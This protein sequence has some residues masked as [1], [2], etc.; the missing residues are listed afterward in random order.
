M[1]KLE[2]PLFRGWKAAYNIAFLIS[3]SVAF[4]IRFLKSNY[5]IPAMHD[6]VIANDWEVIDIKM[7]TIK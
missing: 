1:I 6:P 4:R 3:G 5:V 7:L 2:E